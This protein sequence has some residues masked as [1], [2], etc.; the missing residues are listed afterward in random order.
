M[1]DWVDSILANWGHMAARRTDSGLGYR[2][3]DSSCRGYM[4]G[5]SFDQAMPRDIDASEFDRLTDIIDA[6][7]MEPRRPLKAIVVGRYRDG[8]PFRRIAGAVGMPV[9]T[10]RDRMHEAHVIV[11]NRLTADDS[12]AK[13]SDVATL[14]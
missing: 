9:Q 14:G 7:P 11:A 10:V 8:A 5:R 4:P 2:R 12:R 1:I 13:L 3:I 6:L